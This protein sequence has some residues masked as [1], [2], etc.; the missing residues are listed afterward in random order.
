MGI[1]LEN[2]MQGYINAR[3]WKVFS[4]VPCVSGL[5]RK[6]RK[7]RKF[8]SANRYRTNIYRQP[9]QSENFYYQYFTKLNKFFNLP[10]HCI[11]SDKRQPHL[12][13]LEDKARYLLE[14]GPSPIKKSGTYFKV[15]RN[16]K[17]KLIFQMKFQNFAI[18]PFQIT[19]NKF[20][21]GIQP[22]NIPELLVTFIY[23]YCLLLKTFGHIY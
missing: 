19:I 7:E 23:F 11:S 21:Y 14:D 4:R 22:S 2:L 20:H 3:R 10:S 6:A 5:T 8:Q 9:L 15:K 12:F 17:M 18:V 16:F 13:N 1:S